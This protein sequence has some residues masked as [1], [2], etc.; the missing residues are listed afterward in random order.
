MI[1]RYCV[2]PAKTEG[3]AVSTSESSGSG[4]LDANIFIDLS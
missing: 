2:S 4:A 1:D 3:M